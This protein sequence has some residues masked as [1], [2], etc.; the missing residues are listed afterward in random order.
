MRPLTRTAPP[1]P[2]PPLPSRMPATGRSTE[3]LR[4]PSNEYNASPAFIRSPEFMATDAYHVTARQVADD[5]TTS[6]PEA[7][8]RQTFQKRISREWASP[9]VARTQPSDVSP[10]AGESAQQTPESVAIASAIAAAL[11]TL[12]GAGESHPERLSQA[13]RYIA[14]NPSIALAPS[15]RC[16]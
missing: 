16:Q 13:L 6:L 8:P 1:S 2:P 10:S 11:A 5:R 14:E 12:E 4:P 3:P 15:A 7:P 9:K